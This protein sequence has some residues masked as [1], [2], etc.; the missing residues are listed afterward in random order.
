MTF[1]SQSDV[2]VPYGRI[3]PRWREGGKSPDSSE[4]DDYPDYPDYHASKPLLAA[5]L[6]SHCGGD[7]G[8]FDYLD[9]LVRY[10]QVS[11]IRGIKKISPSEFQSLTK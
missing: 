9:E 8:R 6:Q 4:P 2:P 1:H 3:V 5:T 11:W 7:S 10:L